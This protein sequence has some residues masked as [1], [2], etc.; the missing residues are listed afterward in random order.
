MG[1]YDVSQ[2]CL[3]GH[4]ITCNARRSPEF[5]QAFCSKCGEAT[6]TACP[7]CNEP[8]QGEYHV[9]GVVALGFSDPPPPNFCHACGNPYPWTQRRLDAAKALAE[10]FEN[11]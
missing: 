7:E 2:V 3:N 8:I 5:T 4:T 11:L 9:E 10:E 1:Y 6:V